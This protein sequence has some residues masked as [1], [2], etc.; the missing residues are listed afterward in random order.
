[1][2]QGGTKKKKTNVLSN[3]MDHLSDI[4]EISHNEIIEVK[5]QTNQL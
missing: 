2:N 5:S 1:M 3:Q 4:I